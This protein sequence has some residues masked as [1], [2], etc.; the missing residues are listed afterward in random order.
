MQGLNEDV[1]SIVSPSNTK[2]HQTFDHPEITFFHMFQCMSVGLQDQVPERL[3]VWCMSMLNSLSPFLFFSIA[4][5]LDALGDD[6]ALDEDTSYLDAATAP[7]APDTVPESREPGVSTWAACR[8][9]C[10]CCCCCYC[11]CCCCCC[12]CCYLLLLEPHHEKKDSYDIRIVL[13]GRRSKCF[14]S[15]CTIS[16]RET[17]SGVSLQKKKYR[18]NC[19][20]LLSIF[21]NDNTNQVTS[22][23]QFW[24]NVVSVHFLMTWRICYSF[25]IVMICKFRW[26]SVDTC[27]FKVIQHEDEK[28][29]YGVTW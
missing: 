17:K 6:I 3:F 13:P 12:C 15:M 14:L 29:L 4:V 20:I 24:K 11:Y 25:V 23:S 19:N 5:E 16:S 8:C 21:H 18:Y 10:C 26:K 1:R 7:A 27:M 9:C 28:G 2:N 22:K